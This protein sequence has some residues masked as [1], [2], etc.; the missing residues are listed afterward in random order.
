MKIIHTADLHLDSALNSNLDYDKAKIR[1]NEI[2]LTFGRLVD[3]AVN[4]GVDAVI[5]A[6]DLFDSSAVSA[7]TEQYLFDKISSA[8]DIDFLYL[9]GNHDIGAQFSCPMPN[10]FKPFLNGFCRFDYDGVSIGS[11]NL[12]YEA[13]NEVEF[14]PENYNIAV[15]HGTTNNTSDEYYVN[16][17]ILKNRNIDYLA[18]GHIHKYETGKID[19]RGIYIQTGCLDGRGFDECGE[20]GFVL[21]DTDLK[22]NEFVPF[23][24]RII[25][26]IP[27]NISTVM[28]TNGIIDLIEENIEEIDEKSIVRVVLIGKTDI[29]L[30]KDV[31]LIKSYF[32]NHF[33]SFSLKDNSSVAYDY[34]KYKNDVS[35]KGEFMRLALEEK[36]DEKTISAVINA[37]NSEELPL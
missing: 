17:N 18:L 4:N 30:I 21:I 36:A 7:K 35:L 26:E 3:Y 27:V 37:L 11:I 5:I 28:S 16:L 9:K 29:T 12:V 34:S 25:Y 6:G 1:K 23:S 31:S 15:V 32:E 10:N 24:S 2:L 19:E 20:K 14:S 22:T 8:K 13:Y 33:F